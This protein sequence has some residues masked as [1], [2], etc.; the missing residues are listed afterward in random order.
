MSE[1][2]LLQGDAFDSLG[3]AP[4]SPSTRHGIW[5]VSLAACL[6]TAAVAWSMVGSSHRLLQVPSHDAAHERTV[7]S[8]PVAGGMVRKLPV[9][10]P[11]AYAGA[12]ASEIASLRQSLA[13]ADAGLGQ[14]AR[15]RARIQQ[16]RG[17]ADALRASLTQA[18]RHTAALASAN[19]G[20]QRLVAMEK[21]N[22]QELMQRL[23]GA[24]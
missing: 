18:Q 6:V 7:A 21:S 24:K 9:K 16:L 2:M 19:Q 15:L 22:N 10:P 11:V 1:V 20:L 3:T 4:R 23:R 12:Q 14:E 5:M 17:Q 13:T 8:L